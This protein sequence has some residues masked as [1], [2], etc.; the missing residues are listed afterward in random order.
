M[1][2]DILAVFAGTIGLIIRFILIIALSVIGVYCLGT[3]FLVPL[4]WEGLYRLAGAAGCVLGV[5]LLIRLGR[6]K[7]DEGPAEDDFRP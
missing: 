6:E 4:I 5:V 3:M 2:K 1:L 7:D